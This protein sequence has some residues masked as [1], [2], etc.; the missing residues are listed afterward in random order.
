MAQYMCGFSDPLDE[1]LD[2]NS[3]FAPD[4]YLSTPEMREKLKRNLIEEEFLEPVL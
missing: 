2:E 4:S 1:I 3:K